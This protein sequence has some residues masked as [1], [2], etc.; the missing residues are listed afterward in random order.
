[1]T[2]S[3]RSGS[4]LGVHPPTVGL[5]AQ[6][7]VLASLAVTVSL[8]TAGWLAGAGYALSSYVLLSRA[9]RQPD[10][11]GWG[12]ANT[13]TLARL[14]LAGGVTALVADS[15]WAPPPVAALTA[16]AAVALLLDAVDGQV[17]R[18]RACTSRLG[19]R[20]DMEADSVLVLVLS[21]YVAMSLGWWVLA[22]GAFRYV[23]VVLTWVFPWLTAPL[24]PRMSR[25]VVAALQGVVLV[26]ATAGVL[27]R[28]Q[29]TLA[30]G[31]ALALLVWS[32][33]TDIRW[34][35]R[36]AATTADAAGTLG[37]AGDGAAV[38]PDVRATAPVHRFRSAP[39]LDL[40]PEPVAAGLQATDYP[41][42][43]SER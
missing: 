36:Q 4:A 16:L 12:P 3:A 5:A 15:I 34:S 41:V 6:L 10:V 29:A 14:T 22:I 7:V 28:W 23:F 42:V 18:R 1:M 32:F 33:G 20:F 21:V 8:G 31:A 40:D 9:L 35:W 24:P 25:K 38:P 43:L 11:H 13:V 37:T 17:A 19:A 26:V 30:V 39:T 2:V 27:P